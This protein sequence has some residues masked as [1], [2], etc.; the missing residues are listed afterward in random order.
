MRMISNEDD[1]VKA[2]TYGDLSNIQNDIGKCKFVSFCYFFK[3]GSC[4]MGL[5][6]SISPIPFFWWWLAI[7][8]RNNRIR[9]V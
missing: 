5:H 6:I 3:A 9:Y 1:E 7:K 8:G 2:H 4:S